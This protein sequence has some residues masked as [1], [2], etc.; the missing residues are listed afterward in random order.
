MATAEHREVRERRRP[1]LGPVVDVMALSER[2]IAAWEPAAV[3]AV[4]QRAPYCR[5][6]GPRAGVDFYDPAVA[7]VP[8]HHPVRVAR[9]AAGRFL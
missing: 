4:V 7:V 8:H 5:G 1:A 3:I 2:Q 9:E 6:N